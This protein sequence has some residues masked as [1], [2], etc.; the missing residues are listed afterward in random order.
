M[1]FQVG[2]IIR[3]SNMLSYA[4]RDWTVVAVSG[5]VYYLE[6]Y[7]IN[8]LGGV[9]ETLNE[10]L[11]EAQAILY[12]WTKSSINYPEVFPSPAPV[13]YIPPYVP[14]LPIPAPYVYP[15]KYNVG[16][17]LSH[18]G[19]IYEI[20]RVD[21]EIGQYYF[22]Q[23]QVGNEYSQPIPSVD[24][25]TAWFLYNLVA[26]LPQPAPVPPSASGGPGALIMVGLAMLAL[27]RKKK[28][29]VRG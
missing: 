19:V 3:T 2:D 7:L 27:T 24:N 26:P 13:P 22:R 4:G 25:D 8:H 18:Q 10:T 11:T 29:K 6:N 15:H 5:D 16:Q 1:K 21:T 28:A 14:P 12:G 20:T 17:W 9:E 23:Y